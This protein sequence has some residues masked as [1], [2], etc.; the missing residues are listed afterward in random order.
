MRHTDKDDSKE[1]WNY[2][3][4]TLFGDAAP[5]N[6]PEDRRAELHGD[7]NHKS[8]TYFLVQYHVMETNGGRRKLSEVI[9]FCCLNV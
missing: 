8:V 1:L 3:R 2:W 9:T 4:S 7:A 5:S 6:I